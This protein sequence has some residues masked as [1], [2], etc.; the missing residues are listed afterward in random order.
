MK[1]NIAKTLKL[2]EDLSKRE[3]EKKYNINNAEDKQIADSIDKEKMNIKRIQE[4]I[5]KLLVKKSV[6]F[7]S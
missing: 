1:T 3:K 5:S 2:A 7:H 4:N 6:N